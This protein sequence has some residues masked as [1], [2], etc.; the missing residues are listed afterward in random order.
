MHDPVVPQPQPQP[1]QVG[2]P[3]ESSKTRT[4][5]LVLSI[6]V[7]V[8]LILTACMG[9]GM[10][11]YVAG[12][13]GLGGVFPDDQAFMVGDVVASEVGYLIQTGDMDGY[14]GLFETNDRS[15]DRDA[16]RAEFEAVLAS[17]ETTP[18]SFE[19][20]YDQ[21]FL[22]E[23]Q[24]SGEQL[25][26]VTISGMDWNTGTVRGKRLVVWVVVDELPDVVLTGREGRTLDQG[27]LAW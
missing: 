2:P 9:V 18:T 20:T 14:L 6:V 26:R 13:F 27:R 10:M 4:W 15:V 1:L 8:Q 11:M 17:A 21:V 16:V 25:A 3:A 22:Y 5:L 12:P 23:D 7:G 24:D 19:Y